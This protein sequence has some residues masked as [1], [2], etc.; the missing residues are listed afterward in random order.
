MASLHAERNAP[1]IGLGF[2]YSYF[3]TDSKFAFPIFGKS[4][5]VPGSIFGGDIEV[6]YKHFFGFFGLRL[7]AMASA[8]AGGGTHKSG[9]VNIRSSAAEYFYGGGMDAMV[10]FYD[11]DHS[12][13]GIFGG[14]VV[15]ASQWRLGK[16]YTNGVCATTKEFGD[17]SSGCLT[18]NDFAQKTL[19]GLIKPMGGN[20]DF[21]P[22]HLQISINAGLRGQFTPHQ[23]YEIGVRIPLITDPY[24]ITKAGKNSLP[25]FA[26]LLNNSSVL[27]RNIVAF[28]NYVVNF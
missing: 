23:G 8:Q 2:Q 15:G 9:G 24:L 12:S 21:N 4:G 19:P 14:A 20:I 6:G 26:S 7:Y 22:V 25:F 3:T 5:K 27:K 11:N 17:P 16:V 28:A 18:M 10:N 13:F 1:F